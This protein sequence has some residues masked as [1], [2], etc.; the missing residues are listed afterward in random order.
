[1]SRKVQIW[2]YWLVIGIMASPFEGAMDV[3]FALQVDGSFWLGL[4]TVSFST[5]TLL[6]DRS[7][8]SVQL[9]VTNAVRYAVDYLLWCVIRESYT[10]WC[11]L[12]ISLTEL[13]FSHTS[14]L[15]DCYGV[16]AVSWNSFSLTFTKKKHKPALS[17]DLRS[18]YL[19][20]SHVRRSENN[21]LT[22]LRTA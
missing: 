3:P 15:S 8:L 12:S 18:P 2:N 7:Y 1:M 16:H 9:C 6:H 5:R 17:Q 22:S 10:S 14:F 21:T 11:L 19:R 20:T 13:I 4:V